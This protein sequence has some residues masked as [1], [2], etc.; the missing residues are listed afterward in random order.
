M[1][2]MKKEITEDDALKRLQALC[3]RAEHCTGEMLRKMQLWGI[4][5][6]A[7]RRVV[8]K[9]RKERYVDDERYAR[10]FVSDKV[11]YD[12]WG[13]R[14]VDQALMMK[15]VAEDIRRRALAEIDDSMYAA[16]L[17]PLLEQKL[18]SVKAKDG[19]EMYGKLMRFAASRGYDMEEA[20]ECIEEI[21][22]SKEVEE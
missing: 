7:Q 10:A 13:R 14:K 6:D 21:L 16:A 8:D 17:R 22:K 12:K 15:G 5:E 4:A 1:Q 2:K 19:Y 18:K 3:S 9:L 11:R 20:R